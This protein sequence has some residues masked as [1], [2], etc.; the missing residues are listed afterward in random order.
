[1]FVAIALAEKFERNTHI[2]EITVWQEERNFPLYG[3]VNLKNDR[4]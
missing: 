2:I 1:M 4:V 3:P